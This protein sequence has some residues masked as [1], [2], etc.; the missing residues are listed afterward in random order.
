[1]DHDHRGGPVKIGVGLPLVGE[2]IR[3]EIIAQWAQRAEQ[4][5]LSC[6]GLLDRVVY[7]NYDPLI[8]LA[9]AAGATSRIDLVTSILMTPLR[10][11]ALLAKELASLDNLSGGRLLV[12]VGLGGRPDDY[13]ACGVSWE[14]RGAIFDEQLAELRA[15]WRGEREWTGR[16]IGPVPLRPEGPRMLIGGLVKSVQ[17]TVSYGDGW[18]CG[19][20]ADIKDGVAY[21]HSGNPRGPGAGPERLDEKVARVR[22]AWAEAGRAGDPVIIA[23]AYFT[24][25]PGGRDTARAYLAHFYGHDRLLK[26]DVVN[27]VALTPDRVAAYARAAQDAGCDMLKLQPC[28]KDLDELDRLI[29]AVSPLLDEDRG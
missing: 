6:V 5:G 27:A 3:P 20:I 9:Y 28:G 29:E 23:G 8:A 14:R 22:R 10:P 25:D 16:R 11:T 2:K 12:G 13:E 19:W 4:A 18:I 7:E 17:R 1:M 24:L 15:I 26:E 21:G